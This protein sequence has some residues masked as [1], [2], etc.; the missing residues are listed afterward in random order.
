MRI[1]NWECR[2]RSYERRRTE[3]DDTDSECG[4]VK[5]CPPGCSFG[6]APS[7]VPLTRW[8]GARH[9]KAERGIRHGEVPRLQARSCYSVFPEYGGVEVACL[10]ALRGKA[11]EEESTLRCAA[12]PLD[13]PNRA[14]WAGSSIRGYCRSVNGCHLRCHPSGIYASSI[15]APK[16]P[17]EARNRVKH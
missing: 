14:R 5:G 17:T 10:S 9:S 6:A 7:L 16:A 1:C 12:S 11:G 2:S 3:P 15:A 4:D 13:R 8:E